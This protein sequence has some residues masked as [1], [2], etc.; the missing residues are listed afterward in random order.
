MLLLCGCLAGC[1]KTVPSLAEGDGPLANDAK[2]VLAAL[3]GTGIAPDKIV[4]HELEPGDLVENT[5]SPLDGRLLS[6]RLNTY[7]KRFLNKICQGSLAVRGVKKLDAGALNKA[8]ELLELSVSKSR[9]DRLS[10]LTGLKHLATIDLSTSAVKRVEKVYQLPELQ[11]FVMGKSNALESL[12][13]FHHLPW[14]AELN[15]KSSALA[16]VEGLHH[17]GAKTLELRGKV[18]HLKLVDFPKLRKVYIAKNKIKALTLAKM[19]ELQTIDASQNAI[20]TITL[21]RLPQ[22][23]DLWL[24]R[25]RLTK[26]PT[27]GGGAPK[28]SRVFVNGNQITNLGGLGA[29]DPRELF[30]DDNQLVDL[31]LADGAPPLKRLVTIAAERNRINS[32]R[33]IEAYPQL[34]YLY[35]D[36]NKLTSLE[37]IE[38]A[39]K[40]KKLRVAKNELTSLAPL[41]I[42]KL[43]EL[44]AANNRLTESKALF[45][46]KLEERP[47]VYRYDLRGNPLTGVAAALL[48]HNLRGPS[49]RGLVPPVTN[50]GDVNM[51]IGGLKPSSSGSQ[52]GAPRP[53]RPIRATGQRYSTGGGGYRPGK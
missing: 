42:Q 10:G 4:L 23:E 47:A 46:A 32:L 49:Y 9:L 18:G 14:L 41:P 52:G 11:N 25:N 21:S 31:R 24:S 6:G 53:S 17:L 43:D 34:T 28:L 2:A 36:S 19:P 44:H 30:A 7:A 38:Q 40:L 45:G 51:G 39:K 29:L 8:S 26:L 15:L 50:S 22:L 1:S 33:G 5:R 35:L 20:E 48:M 12:K 16:T 37:G 3:Q 13:D 27:I